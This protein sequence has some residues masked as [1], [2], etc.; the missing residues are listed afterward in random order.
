MNKRIVLFDLVAALFVSC[1]TAKTS[2][3]SEV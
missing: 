1:T 3:A 2:E